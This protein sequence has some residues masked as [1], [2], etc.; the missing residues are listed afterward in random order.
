[1]I[2]GEQTSEGKNLDLFISTSEAIDPPILSVVNA[3]FGN[4]NDS[5]EGHQF[6]EKV[7]RMLW[8]P[9]EANQVFVEESE[10]S[11]QNH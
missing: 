8:K 7:T 10:D 3:C 1:M 2:A 11:S 9:R 4:E 5:R 6:G